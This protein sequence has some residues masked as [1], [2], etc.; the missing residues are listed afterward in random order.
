MKQ[1][2]GIAQALI[3]N[4]SLIIVDEP[5]AGLDPE[6]R[7][8]FPN[9]LSEIGEHV[10]VILSTHIVSDVSYLCHAV[11]ILHEGR[12]AAAGELPGLAATLRGRVWQASPE[13]AGIA[14]YR[15]SLTVLWSR[16]SAGRTQIRVYGEQSPGA[17]FEAVEPEL[18]D[19]YF[20]TVSH[21]GTQAALSAGVPR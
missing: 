2:F 4:P 18:E 10:I 5:T 11:A 7:M 8:R 20:W 15:E 13:R 3:G 9:L 21:G 6:E 17:E 1:R 19:L 16:L 14:G 12:V